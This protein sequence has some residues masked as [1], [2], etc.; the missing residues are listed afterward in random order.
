MN[1]FLTV[2]PIILIRYGL[3]S[4]ISKEGP[5]RASLFAPLL[6][7]EKVAYWIYQITTALILLFLLLLKIRIDSVWFYL[8]L[9]IYILG[10]VL[11]AVSIVTAENTR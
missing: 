3:L 1:A 4:A 7:K 9:I 10:I 6:G 5:K 8:G 11:Y 2:I